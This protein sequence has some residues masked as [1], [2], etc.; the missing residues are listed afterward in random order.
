[1]SNFY[2]QVPSL[3][4]ILNFDY[5]GFEKVVKMKTSGK[6]LQAHVKFLTHNEAKLVIQK[7]NGLLSLFT[8]AV[9]N[10]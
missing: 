10:L 1:M 3:E 7:I 2:A 8:H 4:K 5:L 9:I 6:F